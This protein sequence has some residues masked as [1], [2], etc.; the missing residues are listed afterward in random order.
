MNIG[1]LPF[2]EFKEMARTFHGYP[3]PGVLI[4]GFMVE[5]AKKRMS[6][7]T[8]FDAIVE[9]SKCLPDMCVKND[10]TRI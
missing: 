7:G 8:L 9:T 2:S 6:K 1:Q 3:A 5:A 4:G 10:H